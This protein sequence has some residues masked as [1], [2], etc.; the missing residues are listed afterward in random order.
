MEYKIEID[1][2]EETYMREKI[3]KCKIIALDEM[4]KHPLQ[5]PK[6]FTNRERQTLLNKVKELLTK[7]MVCITN[8][9]NDI[10]AEKLFQNGADFSQYAVYVD[11]RY[12]DQQKKID[13]EEPDLIKLK[14]DIKTNKLINPENIKEI[15]VDLIGKHI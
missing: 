15:E 12:P 11:K 4:D 7:D 5:N 14:E 10:C 6:F 9:F 3:M 1:P 8:M 2:A 13:E